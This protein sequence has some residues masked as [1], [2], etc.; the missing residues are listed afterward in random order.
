MDFA[1]ITHAFV[2]EPL[3][4]LNLAFPHAN[5]PKPWLVNPWTLKPCS[6]KTLTFRAHPVP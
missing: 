5:N 6:S 3:M 2:L 1:V 4:L